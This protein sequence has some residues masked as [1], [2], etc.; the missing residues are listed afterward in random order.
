[1][2]EEINVLFSVPFLSWCP[3]SGQIVS[4]CICTENYTG[5]RIFL[6]SIYK[7][8][9]KGLCALKQNFD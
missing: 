4:D 7:A 3:I 9:G 5:H 6:E 8:K 1:M 2:Q